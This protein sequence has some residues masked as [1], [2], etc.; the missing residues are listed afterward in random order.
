MWKNSIC[1][2]NSSH[3]TG[4]KKRL[5]TA[6]TAQGFDFQKSKVRILILIHLDRSHGQLGFNMES[7]PAVHMTSDKNFICQQKVPFGDI[8]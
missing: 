2:S 1:I 3:L 4:K 8:K 6:I 7:N 5:G